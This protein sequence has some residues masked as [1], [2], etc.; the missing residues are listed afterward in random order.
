MLRKSA[1]SRSCC[2]RWLRALALAACAALG[3]VSGFAAPSR[4]AL[5]ERLKAGTV[6]SEAFLTHIQTGIDFRM[7]S[8]ENVRQ[9]MLACRSRL[10]DGRPP[11]FFV[12]AVVRLTSQFM[13]EIAKLRQSEA[14][15]AYARQQLALELTY[16]GHSIDEMIALD[17]YF[18]SI[19]GQRARKIEEAAAV[20]RLLETA[21]RD[22]HSGH[23]WQWPIGHVLAYMDEVG[24]R[25]DFLSAVE[26]E[27]FETSRLLDQVTV[28]MGQLLPEEVAERIDR[29]SWEGVRGQLGRVLSI[30]DTRLLT[31][32]PMER[33]LYS[34]EVA[35]A[36]SRPGAS[37][38]LSK[39]PQQIAQI[40]CDLAIGKS[41]PSEV[42]ERV[43]RWQSVMR[44]TSKPDVARLHK[45]IQAAPESGC[46]AIPLPVVSK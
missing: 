42:V 7:E 43:R 20:I 35:R 44:E 36:F 27:R 31:N 41:C 10:V 5:F 1:T 12:P 18:R 4:D 17:D 6:P 19:D 21:T 39:D 8:Y 13:P 46:S 24:F 15:V 30:R 26:N 45:M 3:A 37:F 29:I 32:P 11:A 22:E 16:A 28:E 34:N 33:Y 38:T 9:A 25:A 23:S 2:C 40:T 14:N